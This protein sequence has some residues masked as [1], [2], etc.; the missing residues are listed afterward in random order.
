MKIIVHIGGKRLAFAP[1]YFNQ[2]NFLL[3]GNTKKNIQHKICNLLKKQS[4]EWQ[5]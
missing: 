5:K 1:S 3:I 4:I 2:S